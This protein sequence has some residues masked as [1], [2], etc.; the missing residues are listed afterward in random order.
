MSLRSPRVSKNISSIERR[1]IWM[2]G[3]CNWNGKGG[4]GRLVDNNMMDDGFRGRRPSGQF[5]QDP[6]GVTPNL[7]AKLKP[8]PCPKLKPKPWPKP[9]CMSRTQYWHEVNDTRNYFFAVEAGDSDFEFT[10]FDE[11]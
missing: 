9:N 11:R 7:D 10:I 4:K 3:R 6:L 5:G 2:H 8:K 1:S